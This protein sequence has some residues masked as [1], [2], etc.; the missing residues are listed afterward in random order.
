MWFLWPKLKVKS[1]EVQGKCGCVG[2]CSFFGNNENGIGFFKPSRNDIDRKCNVAIPTIKDIKSPGYGQSI[3]RENTLTVK[4]CRIFQ[5]FAVMG[6]QL[7]PQQWPTGCHQAEKLPFC[8][9]FR[10]YKSSS[11][12]NSNETPKHPKHHRSFSGKHGKT[13]EDPIKRI[14][15]SSSSATEPKRELMRSI[16]SA[17][18][19]SKTELATQSKSDKA[20]SLAE[21]MSLKS[22]VSKYTLARTESLI[23][24]VLSFY[25]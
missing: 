15:S 12:N 14:R 3:L 16:S 24:D 8:P 4:D 1:K 7:L 22:D 25:R 11:S 20:E 18:S 5:S 13:R 6:E 2:G 10:T 19:N 17:R 9:D 21:V 23:S